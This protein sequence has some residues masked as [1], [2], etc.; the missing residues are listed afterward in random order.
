MNAIQP[1]R[2]QESLYKLYNM[3]YCNFGSFVREQRKFSSPCIHPGKQEINKTNIKKQTNKQTDRQTDRP[4]DRQIDRQTNRQPDNQTENQ[5]GR[6]KTNKQTKD[7][8]KRRKILF[9]ES[10]EKNRM[11]V[12]KK[13]TSLACSV[14]LPI[15]FVKARWHEIR[16]NFLISHIMLNIITSNHST[17]KSCLF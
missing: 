1:I 14:I 5:T 16:F 2:G 7:G 13:S 9:C 4:T 6:Q 10:N 17:S 8:N 12:P 15:V 11:H 3:S